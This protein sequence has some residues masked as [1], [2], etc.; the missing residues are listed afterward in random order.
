MPDGAW[1]AL[2]A[3]LAAAGGLW[4]WRT[5][6]APFA[7]IRRWAWRWLISL[8]GSGRARRIIRGW[9]RY[10]RR[11]GPPYYD[12]RMAHGGGVAGV[13]HPADIGV[14]DGRMRWYRAATAAGVNPD[15]RA[16]NYADCNG[17]SFANSDSDTDSDGYA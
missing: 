4:L 12:C 14:A 13:R 6:L 10:R 17:N 15:G 11:C 2:A 16:D 7:A 8:T 3:L 9:R 1:L 5:R